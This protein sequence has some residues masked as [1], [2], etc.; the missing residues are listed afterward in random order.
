M[1]VP[2]SLVLEYS[3]YSTNIRMCKQNKDAGL[4]V[5]EVAGGISYAS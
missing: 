3:T 4:L 5:S 2:I 1:S